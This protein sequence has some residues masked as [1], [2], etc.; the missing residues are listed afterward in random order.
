MVAAKHPL[1]AA[2]GLEVLKDGGNAVDA[3]VATAFAIGVVEPFMSGVGGGGN[4]LIHLANGETVDIDY[5]PRAP[6]KAYPD[7]YELEEGS[8]GA[9]AW[10]SVKNNEN[11]IG[12]KA[13]CV[14]GTVAGLCAA[15]D[16][17][18]TMDLERILKPAIRLAEEGFPVSSYCSICITR[19]VEALARFPESAKI[20]LKDGKFPL[21]PAALVPAFP[22]DRLVQRDLA[23][24]L[25]RIARDGPDA[26]YRG[27]IAWAIARDME[28]NGGVITDGDLEK[29]GARFLK[30]RYVGYRGLRVVCPPTHGGVTLL[31][32]MRILDGFDLT[33]MGHGTVEAYHVIGEAMR[34]A[35][36]DRLS[37]LWDPESESVDI[38]GLLSDAHISEIRGQITSKGRIEAPRSGAEVGHTTH[39]SVVDKERNMV[40]LTQTLLD[41]FGCKVTVKGTGVLLNNG[42]AWFNPKPGSIASIKPNKYPMSAITPTILLTHNNEPFVSVGAVGYRRITGAVTNIVSNIVD[43]GMGIQEA[44]DAPRLD[45]STNVLYIDSRVPPSVVEG[46]RSFGHRVECV[47]EDIASS[48]FASPCGILVDR[49]NIL[50][51]G[52]DSLKPD[53][54]VLGW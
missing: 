10:P 16:K 22:A 19:E 49:Q 30:P 17:Y 41:L 51:G 14:P 52:K 12:Y 42:M 40:S 5:I 9:Y 33:S 6:S 21:A 45:Y 4:M 26:F 29:Y 44:I 53:N 35:F 28:E 48:N 54:T 50:H 7:M 32:V 43:F 18:G 46:L 11:M 3:A 25:R 23:E 38:D 47:S 20:F 1:A 13:A 37:V 24:T 2:V 15:L 8:F 31:E 27:E 39:L 34:W 36:R